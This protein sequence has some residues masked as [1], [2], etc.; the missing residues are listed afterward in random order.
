MRIFPVCVWLGVA[1]AAGPPSLF[2][3]ERDVGQELAQRGA[4]PAFV[5]VVMTQVVYATEGVSPAA[6]GTFML[7]AEPAAGVIRKGDNTFRARM[8]KRSGSTCALPVITGLQLR[9]RYQS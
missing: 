7:R 6:C 9:I 8:K 4:P 1:A 3:Q 5:A 2:A